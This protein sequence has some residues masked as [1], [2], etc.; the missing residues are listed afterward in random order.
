MIQLWFDPSI[1]GISID[2]DWKVSLQHH[3]LLPGISC[4]FMQLEVQVVLNEKVHCIVIIVI[5]C[6]VDKCCDL[7]M[8]I[9]G[10][11][12]PF[13]KV[14]CLILIPYSAKCRIGYEPVFVVFIVAFEARV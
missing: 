3:A 9:N 11:I 2:T 14:W 7:I 10:I 1:Y 4:R 5:M 6:R 13:I 8:V 12:P